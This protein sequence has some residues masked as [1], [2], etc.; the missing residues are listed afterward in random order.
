MLVKTSWCYVRSRL[1]RIYLEVTLSRLD[2]LLIF[3]SLFFQCDFGQ[4]YWTLT[5]VGA[6]L[7]RLDVVW[8]YVLKLSNAGSA[9]VKRVFVGVA[10]C[11]ICCPPKWRTLAS[12]ISHFYW[13]HCIWS[14]LLISG[15]I[16]RT[17]VSVYLLIVPTVTG[18]LTQLVLGLNM[19]LY[20]PKSICIRF[21]E[22]FEAVC[23]D[24]VSAQGGNLQWVAICNISRCLFYQWQSYSLLLS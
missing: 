16:F 3:L 9:C 8:S 13:W 14:S 17:Y 22:Q 20:V 23:S 6:T 18:F 10:Q 7:L 1:L 12:F 2:I 15:V 4:V 19:K 24:I 11:A 5:L 21:G